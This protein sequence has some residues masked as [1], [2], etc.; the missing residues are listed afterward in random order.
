MPGKKQERKKMLRRTF[1]AGMSGFVVTG[2]V[3]GNGDGGDDGG[4]GDDEEQPT[5]TE[6]LGP[7]P[8]E[9]GNATAV[10]GMERED[11]ENLLSYDDVNYQSEPMS[12]QR[13]DGCTYWIPDQ[14]GDDLGACAI[15]E[16]DIE[17]D[18]WC[19]NY[20]PQT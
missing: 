18:G 10:G 3:G 6:G 1:L 20:A 2:C 13:C 19:S 12:D 9:Y 11:P 15:V 14:N 5:R 7:V 8:E 17:P 4:D 16:N